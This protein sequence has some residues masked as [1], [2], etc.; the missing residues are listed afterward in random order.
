METREAFGQARLSIPLLLRPPMP[1]GHWPLAPGDTYDLRSYRDV[2]LWGSQVVP[3]P[4]L[5]SADAPSQK[6]EDASPPTRTRRITRV[7]DH[8]IVLVGGLSS[9]AE[10]PNALTHYNVAHFLHRTV[11]AASD[12]QTNSCL[13]IVGPIPGYSGRHRLLGELKVTEFKSLV[14]ALIER[15]AARDPTLGV[16]WA[17]D[18]P[19]ILHDILLHPG[20]Y[21]L[22]I[23]DPRSRESL[24]TCTFVADIGYRRSQRRKMPTAPKIAKLRASEPLP[25]TSSTNLSSSAVV[26]ATPE[27][28]EVPK[29]ARNTQTP[30]YV[31]ER[32][33]GCVVQG[34]EFLRDPETGEPDKVSFEAAHGL[35]FA[36]IRDGAD[37]AERWAA[38]SFSWTPPWTPEDIKNVAKYGDTVRNVVMIQSH[39][40]LNFDAL[41]FGYVNL[42][43]TQ[44]QRV[45]AYPLFNNAVNVRGFEPYQPMFL[46]LHGEKTHE[47]PSQIYFDLHFHLCLLKYFVGNGVGPTSRRKANKRK[48]A[49]EA[50]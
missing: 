6:S 49:I 16:T 50:E 35:A 38:N 17:N 12:D 14:A 27:V 8:K 34:L 31:A 18:Q 39:L 13:A 46:D 3:S 41:R 44:P 4:L 5:D 1:L 23:A 21:V 9:N 36:E 2:E 19:L 48:R 25:A 28:N 22:F 42:D 40:H 33:G 26:F 7:D 11:R 43:P 20:Q 47:R 29:E 24:K 10:T 15:V 45:V 30:V 32:D 37:W